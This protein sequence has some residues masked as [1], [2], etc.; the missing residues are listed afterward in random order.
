[1]KLTLRFI[2]IILFLAFPVHPGLARAMSS[3]GAP[4]AYVVTIPDP[5]KHVFHV[6]MRVNRPAST[7]QVKMPTWMEAAYEL[8][9]YAEQVQGL[10][11]HDDVGTT[12]EALVVDNHTWRFVMPKPAPV[13]IEY[14]VDVGDKHKLFSKSYLEKQTGVISGG[15]F[16]LYEPGER[17]KP[18]TVKI[19]L[20]KGWSA[21][22]SLDAGESASAP[23]S[24]S[25]AARDY[26]ELIDS[27]I[28]LG[29][30][31]RTDFTV[32]GIPF[33]V[34]TDARMSHRL[35]ELVES[36]R[37]IATR[38]LDFFGGAPFDRYLFIYYSTSDPSGAGAK[39]ALLGVEHLKSTLITINP[40]FEA[41]A[42]F[43]P[44]I[45]SVSAHELFH[46]W[47]VKAIRPVALNHPNFDAAASVRSLWLL[48]GFTEY[49]ARKFMWQLYGDGKYASFYSQI[50]NYL[51]QSQYSV[52]LAHLS[53]NA[54]FESIDQFGKLYTKGTVAGLLLDLKL[55][56]LTNN[57][58]G[59]DDFM[60]QLWTTYG[61]SRNPYNEDDLLPV[62][63][64]VA[65]AQLGEYYQ[66]YIIGLD[67]L[68]LKEY[69][70]IG[71]LSVT[72]TEQKS[73]YIGWILNQQMLVANLDRDGNAAKAGIQIGD[74]LV[75]IDKSEVTL[76]TMSKLVNNFARGDAVNCTVERKGS[77]MEVRIKPVETLLVNT[78]LTELSHSSASQIATRRAILSATSAEKKDGTN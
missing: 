36:A 67:A 47:N 78:V 59:L 62:L 24:I 11:A 70:A 13:I 77:R 20:P 27:P 40:E 71:G 34:I 69:L 66:R 68:P 8:Q 9:N 54:P 23:D 52:S 41:T 57:D 18:A 38:E 1:M 49:Y 2:G 15:T 29:I 48:E 65:S 37:Q 30:F 39:I 60:R 19:N 55:R 46:A 75:A 72:G 43:R 32:Q 12:I 63:E 58:R 50:S 74:K 35:T 4:T 76:Q 33:S 44:E 14:D 3:D 16:F 25:F 21:A 6:A 61:R 10:K 5:N 64:R 17:N 28:M 42:R 56:Q 51:V 26:D 45:R 53:L 7:L 31:K 73:P 22:A